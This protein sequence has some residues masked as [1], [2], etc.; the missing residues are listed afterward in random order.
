[1]S[2]LALSRRGSASRSFGPLTFLQAGY[3]SNAEELGKIAAELRQIENE[4][5]GDL[6]DV[7]KDQPQKGR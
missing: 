1:M 7:S 2:R 3:G 6:V 5:R 4:E